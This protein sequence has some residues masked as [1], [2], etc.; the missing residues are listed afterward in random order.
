MARRILQK[1]AL[2]ALAILLITLCV[3]FA[4]ACEKEGNVTVSFTVKGTLVAGSS[5]EFKIDVTGK[6]SAVAAYEQETYLFE[7]VD[8]ADVAEI[9]DNVLYLSDTA[10][11]GDSFS[12]RMTVNGETFVKEF[13]VAQDK[14]IVVESVTLLCANSAK[15]GETIEL[16]S[17]VLPEG[18]NVLPVYSVVSGSATVEGNLLKVSD[19][20]DGGEIVIKVTAGGVSS[21]EKHLT[22]ST[23][24]TR[25]LTLTAERTR[26]LPGES[27]RFNAVK[28]PE[29]STYPIEFSLEKGEAVAEVDDVQCSLVIKEDAPMLSE[30]ILVAR[31]GKKEEK[32]TFVVDYPAAERIDARTNAG[33]VVPGNSRTIDFS[34]YPATA[35]RA[36]VRI[37][38][39]VGE[40][41]VEWS[42]GDSFRVIP[43]APQGEEITFLLDAGGEVATTVSFITG[44]KQLT[45]LSISTASATEY[46]RSGA[47]VIFTHASVPADTDQQIRYRATAG[48]DLVQ[49][50]DNVVTVNEG[51]GIGEVTIV[52]ESDDGTLS[53][54]VTF[55]VSGRYSR[56]VYSSWA[57][58][59]FSSYR[60]EASVWMVLPQTMNAGC[61]TVLVPYQVVDLVIEGRYDGVDEATAYKDLYFYFRNTAA[62]TVTLWNFATIATQGLG[63]TIFDLGSSGDTEIVLK[64]NNLI[65]ADSPFRL[66]NSGED[67]DGVWNTAYSGNQQV[68]RRNGK[69]GYRGTAGGTAISGYSLTFVSYDGGKLTAVAGSGVNGTA[70]GNGADAVYDGSLA[71]C[72]GSGGNGGN[73]G[74]SGSAIYAYNAK[75]L[76]GL[77]TAIPGNAGIGGAGGLA[78]SITAVSSYNV[79]K[80]AGE[81]GADGQDGTPYPAVN[82]KNISGAHYLSSTGEVRSANALYVG[83]LADLTDRISGFYGVNVYYGT[84]LYNPYAR[85]SKG[86][87]NMVAQTDASALMQQANFLMYTMSVMPKNCWREVLDRSGNKVEIYLCKSIRSSSSVILGLTNDTNHVWFA[88]FDTD[89]RG[90][91]YSGYFNIMLHEFTHVFH[92]NFGSTARTTFEAAVKKNYNYVDYKTNYSGLNEYVYGMDSAY[93]EN[94]C[95]FFTSYSRKN[96][97]EDAAETLSIAATF[98]SSTAPLNNGTNMR[99]K[100]LYLSAA[101]QREYETFSPFITGAVLFGDKRLAIA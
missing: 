37:S 7:I 58:V 94:N 34:L 99:N 22:V 11:E 72:S 78:G 95:C 79:N 87:Y 90:V 44:K 39:L 82:A 2:V 5:L 71:Y 77:I 48:G 56:R 93:D 97:M 3:F 25:T 1:T 20:A 76:S 74:D 23:V 38:I 81:N 73:G 53:N 32:L 13:T 101:F 18:I 28:L 62:R 50:N 35:N 15:A 10:H 19:E 67:V 91:C 75:F 46:L 51:A 30:I 57:N 60:E 64:G 86:G 61:L 41:Y 92:Y 36:S 9:K 21:E 55:T 65:R 52:A 49:I 70:G 14:P 4:C 42:G 84:N 12:V 85:K 83:S 69:P 16:H 24:Q 6:E 80:A 68:A 89:L 33:I 43:T 8:G 40:D 17:E 47:S 31:S 63:G 27:L 96:A 29:T 88:T 54:E 100:V 26:A 59:N 66:D 45:S 98:S